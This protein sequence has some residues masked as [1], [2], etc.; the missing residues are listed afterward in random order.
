AE[1]SSFTLKFHY[2]DISSLQEL[3][4]QYPNQ[5]AGVILEPATT[6]GPKPSDTLIHNGKP[7]NFLHEVKSLCHNAGA[8]FILDEMITGFRWAL[9]GAQGFYD[10]EPDLA[11]F[12][13]AM[14]NGFAVAAL[15][16]KKEIMGIG[17]ILNEGQE[18][19]F[20]T[21]TTHGA[22]MG[23]LGAFIK[24]VEIIKRDDVINH[25]W[26]FGKSLIDGMNA[27]AKEIGIENY[28]VAEGYG[29][30]PNYITRN[31]D[32]NT[33]FELRTLFSQE[34]LKKGVMMPYIALCHAH[35]DAELNMTLDAVRSA[36]NIYAGALNNGVDKYL[37]SAAIKPVFRKY[38]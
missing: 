11:T 13:K 6:V 19:V 34:V 1:L 24:T 16:G 5:I 30:S 23:A 25:L 10:V 17:G 15:T 3:F 8:V 27:I 18:R 21:S 9:N 28:F 26:L 22:E 29:C 2:N 20:L 37:Q 36:L 12:G 4:D 33:S 35:S 38:N 14:A 7:A 31:K 32:G